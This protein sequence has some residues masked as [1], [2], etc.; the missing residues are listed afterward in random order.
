VPG[1]ITILDPAPEQVIAAVNRSA[2]AQNKAADALP[3]LSQDLKN[4]ADV[5]KAY[6]SAS[7]RR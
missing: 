4:Q 7:K 6:D 2:S 1:S 3:N 5:A